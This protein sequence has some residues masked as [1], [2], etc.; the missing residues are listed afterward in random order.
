M[1]AE[2]RERADGSTRQRLLAAALALVD[3]EGEAA[4]SMRRLAARV[5]VSAPA[6]YRHFADKGALLQCLVDEANAELGRHLVT[7]RRNRGPLPGMVEGYLA[8]AVER[9]QLYDVL[10]F[11]RGRVDVEIPPSGESSENF[12]LLRDAV[13]A[14]MNGGDLRHA[15]VTQTTVT[16]WALMHGLVALQR[17]G[18]FGGDPKRFA[19][20]FWASLEQIVTGLA[21]AP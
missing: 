20:V 11:S 7:P 6:L 19:E 8:F 18:R 2:P 14:A 17:Q 13:T 1:A 21:P 5:G 10:F 12:R 16:L 4:L 15:D 3:E 9:P